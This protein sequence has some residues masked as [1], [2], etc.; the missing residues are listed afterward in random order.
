MRKG[1]VNISLIVIYRET[2]GRDQKNACA[3]TPPPLHLHSVTRS[4]MSR[5]HKVSP[6]IVAAGKW[7][8]AGRETLVRLSPV[9]MHSP[10]GQRAHSPRK[11]SHLQSSP[12][13]VLQEILSHGMGCRVG[14]MEEVAFKPAHVGYSHAAGQG[15]ACGMRTAFYWRQSFLWWLL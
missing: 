3:F 11:W 12:G 4:W 10:R 9:S 2:L 13:E 6:S 15:K 8:H 5:M 7:G 1:F 14:F